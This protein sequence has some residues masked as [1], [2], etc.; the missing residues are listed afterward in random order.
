MQETWV[1][2]LGWEDPLEKEM[3]TL[4]SILAWKIPWTEK[5]GRLQSMRS[6]RVDT[7]EWL[8]FHF[9]LSCIEG[10][11]GNPLQ[12]SCL[13]NPR[14]WGAL[15]AS[16][17][18]VTQSRTRLKWLSSRAAYANK[19][20]LKIL[21]ARPQQYVNHELP[22]AQA[23]FRKEEPEIKLPT[24]AESSKKQKSSRKTSISALLTMPKPL[25]V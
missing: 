7:T 11:N 13:E 21:Q 2:F 1:G 24:P 4:S 23:G 12:C 16:V 14:D 19:V 25:T 6:Q 18:G 8:H 10:G 9:S 17:C 5:P 20:M 22:D 15:W 3:A